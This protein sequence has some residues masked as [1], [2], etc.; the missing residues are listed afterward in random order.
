M[1]YPDA[2]FYLYTSFDKVITKVKWGLKLLAH[3]V[4]QT[5]RTAGFDA[6]FSVSKNKY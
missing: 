6:Q 4:F 5:E 2:K 3:P 1:A